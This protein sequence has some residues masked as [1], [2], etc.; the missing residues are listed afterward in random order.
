MNEPLFPCTNAL[1][2]PNPPFWT[3]KTAVPKFPQN[4]GSTPTRCLDKAVHAQRGGGGEDKKT[5]RDSVREGFQKQGEGTRSIA[6]MPLRR[7]G[8]E[9]VL[10]SHTFRRNS[11]FTPRCSLTT[12]ICRIASASVS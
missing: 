1:Q 3:T 5:A 2:T 12:S 8:V 11:H 7:R 6:Q 9:Q 4:G 10:H